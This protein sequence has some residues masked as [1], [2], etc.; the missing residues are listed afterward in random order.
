VCTVSW[1]KV[2]C[3]NG[4]Q[5]LQQVVRPGTFDSG[6]S[7]SADYALA[8]GPHN[9][10][11]AMKMEKEH[12]G[13]PRLLLADDNP[14]V[15]SHV[16]AIL[17]RDF[18]TVAV[19]DG[20]SVLRKYVD[21]QPDVIVLD[22]SMGKMSGL[23]VARILRQKGCRAPIVFLTVHQGDDFVSTALSAGASGYVLKAHMRS[24]L[25]PAINAAM[26]GELFV[27]SPAV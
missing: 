27:S 2:A 19:S 16:C 12:S 1:A 6:R 8:M 15:L 3:R 14:A 5:R 20:E 21:F 26:A 7:R 17:G 25:L 23:D 13:N 4:Q 10:L 11:T 9:V 18:D 24:D 22:I